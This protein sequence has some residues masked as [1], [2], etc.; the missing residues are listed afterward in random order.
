MW[1]IPCL[2]VSI[3]LIVFEQGSNP[4]RK[5]RYNNRG[6]RDNIACPG[7]ILFQLLLQKKTAFGRSKKSEQFEMHKCYFLNRS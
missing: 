5:L 1:V 2:G 7:C 6:E 4:W 3:F